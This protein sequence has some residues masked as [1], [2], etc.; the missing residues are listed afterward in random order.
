MTAGSDA[1]SRVETHE[2]H[3][4]LFRPVLFAGAEPSVVVLEAS[5][6]FAL[7][8]GIGLH[9][10]TI[11]LAGF[12]VTLVHSIMVWVASQDSQMT[13]LYIRS[14]GARDFYAPHSAAL[15]AAPR[16]VASIPRAM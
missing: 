9:V 4:S 8:F 16:L 11:L 6:A 5:T 15:E 1:E 12:Y 14:L 2:M 13:A 7:I 3:T 10:A